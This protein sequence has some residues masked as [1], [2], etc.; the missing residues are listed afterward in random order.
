M[1]V[2]IVHIDYD[3]FEPHTYRGIYVTGGDSELF[4][5]FTE[6]FV[7]DW[8]ALFDW[9]APRRE[10]AYVLN[11]SSVDHFFMDTETKEPGK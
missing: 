9:L 11:S 5:V 6:N 10:T 3:E 7:A 1:N 4:R 2:L 8:N